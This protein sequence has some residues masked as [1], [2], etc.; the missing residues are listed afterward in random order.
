M[1]RAVRLAKNWL[2]HSG[3]QSTSGDT[4]GGFHSWY[5]GQ[6]YPYVY[7][8]ITGYG[9]TT[10]LYLNQLNLDKIFTER[11]EL[12][13][14]WL[15]NQ[16]IHPC[17]G[18]RGYD[19]RKGFVYTFDTGM[20]LFGI[21]H[22]YNETRKEKYI[23]CARRLGD[24]LL[25]M[26]KSDGG[27]YAYFDPK[28]QE[29]VDI[30]DRW[31]KQAGAYH[32]KLA[33]GLLKLFEITGDKRYK[34]GTY[35]LG[36]YALTL[37]QPDGRFVTFKKGGGTHIHPHC[38]AAEG[39]LFA[40]R[41]LSEPEFEEAARKATEWSFG[42]QMENG[43]VPSVY[44]LGK[45]VERLERVDGLAQVLRLGLL[46]LDDSYRDRLAKLAERLSSFQNQSGD[47]A[48]RGGFRYGSDGEGNR[49]DC[50]NSWCTMF[51]LQALKMYELKIVRGVNLSVDYLI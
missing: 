47:A 25:G 9:I 51:A 43:G 30:P 50:V 49:P 18:V 28:K 4:K 1:E 24:F 35:K 23:E 37:Q 26:Q 2:L 14:S 21:A 38:Y 11:A 5:D 32:A 33:L 22:L 15:V 3:I 17:G 20:V 36:E 42:N 41:Y 19:W 44:Y 46:T 10:L 29:K 40:G 48:Q 13:A 39:L 6:G 34:E 31:S 12:A 45:R 8:E 27:F 7:P 16:A